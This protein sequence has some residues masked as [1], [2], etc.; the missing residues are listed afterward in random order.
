[1]LR[2]SDNLLIDA[3]RF[4]DDL[5]D[6]EGMIMVQIAGEGCFEPFDEQLSG[7]V[8][9]LIS[10]AADAARALS[11]RARRA[12]LNLIWR[13]FLEKK[14]MVP[15]RPRPVDRMSSKDYSDLL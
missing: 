7:E 11:P 4:Y 5:L 3:C 8:T 9:M 6:A 15:P 12:R 10:S 2:P 1:M 13:E 14:S